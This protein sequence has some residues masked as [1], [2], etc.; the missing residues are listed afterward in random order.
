MF[1]GTYSGFCARPG[2]VAAGPSGA[3]QSRCWPPGG[4]NDTPAG[5]RQ[6]RQGDLAF[7]PGAPLDDVDERVSVLDG[8]SRLR[9]LSGAGDH[10]GGDADGG[11][12]GFDG[13][14]DQVGVRR[15]PDD[16][17]WLGGSSANRDP[18]VFENPRRLCAR[19]AR[20]SACRLCR[21]TPIG[22]WAP[23]SLAASWSSRSRNGTGSFRTTGS[24]RTRR[25]SSGAP[26]SPCS[27]SRSSGNARDAGYL[28]TNRASVRTYLII[29][30]RICLET[31]GTPIHSCHT[32]S[33]GGVTPNTPGGNVLHTHK[34]WSTHPPEQRSNASDEARLEGFR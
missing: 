5:L 18:R 21:R 4:V 27:R 31:L 15:V 2:Y 10:H 19:S 29:I 14:A 13:G 7:A 34:R 26:N 1:R 16:M 20:Q 22:A 24:Q 3:G 17:V 9:W 32:R 11:E 6:R 33:V 12:V 30:I 8:S 28:P 23:I 25:S